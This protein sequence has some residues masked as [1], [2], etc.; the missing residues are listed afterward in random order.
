MAVSS[1]NTS[2]IDDDGI[3]ERINYVCH[4]LGNR[5]CVR[6][7]MACLLGKLDNPQVDPRKPYTEIGDAD[8]FSGRTYDERYL[9]PFINRYRLP[10]NQTTAF[11]TPTLRNINHT[12]TAN[13]NLVGRPKELYKKT[14]ALLEDVSNG[15]IDAEIFFAEIVRLLILMRDE[16]LSR[17]NSLLQSL[18]RTHNDIHQLSA[19]GIVT[20]LKQ[21]L[22]CKKSS[23]LPVL[24]V[25]AA[26][27][28]AGKYLSEC[29]LPLNPHNAADIQ[30]GALGDVE[31][32]LSDDNHVVTAYEMKMRKVTE[33]DIDAAVNKIMR[34]S[35]GINHYVFITTEN[36]D[37]EVIKYVAQLNDKIEGV[38]IAILDCID[39]IRYF[40]HI[41]YRIRTEYIDAYQRFVLDEPDSAVSQPLKEAF[42]AL[43]QAAESG[44]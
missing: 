39:F 13:S 40:L 15:K 28:V 31:I 9:T 42:L 30:T 12:L 36:V 22:A 25:A 5:S 35:S 23:R 11:L 16:K 4:Y 3:K 8:C 37:Q 2:F 38:E 10:V 24:M 34:S 33:D 17:I 26:Y 27:D 1:L 6:L 44:E 21:H 7:L 29:M 43:R 41:F 19:D 32:C 14:I 20:L 18:Q